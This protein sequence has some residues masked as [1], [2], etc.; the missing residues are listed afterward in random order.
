[1]RPFDLILIAGILIAGGM[2]LAN[3]PEAARPT[4][5]CQ[6]ADCTC[7]PCECGPVVVDEPDEPDHIVEPNKKVEAITYFFTMP[8]CVPCEQSKPHINAAYQEGYTVYTVDLERQDLI[9]RYGVTSWPTT[10]VTRGG[11]EIDRHTGLIDGRT[12]Q[13]ILS[14][15]GI[16]PKQRT[17]PAATNQQRIIRQDAYRQPAMRQTGWIRGGRVFS[18]CGPGGCG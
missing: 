4:P 12:L 13:G 11:V 18:A 3:K 6:C 7:D 9:D 1:M 2:S 5:D 17:I 10:V 16:Q 14:N 15:H 8:A